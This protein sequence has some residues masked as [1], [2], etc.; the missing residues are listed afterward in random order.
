[1]F[2]SKHTFKVTYAK[3]YGKDMQF[4]HEDILVVRCY[5]PLLFRIFNL[6]SSTSAIRLCRINASRYLACS[7]ARWTPEASLLT[8]INTRSFQVN[9]D[10]VIRIFG[11][12]IPH[13]DRDN[14]WFVELGEFRYRDHSSLRLGI[15]V[16]MTCDPV[17]NI[18][19]IRHEWDW[20]SQGSGNLTHVSYLE[21]DVDEPQS[22]VMFD[23]DTG[24]SIHRGRDNTVIVDLVVKRMETAG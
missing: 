8:W 19:R 3:V 15:F 17:D 16:S 23:E 22:I 2:S 6:K 18:S 10:R 11:F 7:N 21:H 5:S 14:P 20:R 24:R 12:V 4:V 9:G 1:V 13:N